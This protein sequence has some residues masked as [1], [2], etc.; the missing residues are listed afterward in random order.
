[1]L[2]HIEIISYHITENCL[3]NFSAQIIFRAQRQGFRELFSMVIKCPWRTGQVCASQI[4]ILNKKVIVK[5]SEIELD[6]DS[7]LEAQIQEQLSYYFIN[8]LR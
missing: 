2:T 5:E 4:E 3:D 8:H 7:M 6:L 1:M